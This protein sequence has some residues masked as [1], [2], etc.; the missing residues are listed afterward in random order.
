MKKKNLFQQNFVDVFQNISE[1][2]EGVSEKSN[3]QNLEN[4]FKML[5]LNFTDLRV[6]QY[7]VDRFKENKINQYNIDKEN[8]T[9]PIQFRL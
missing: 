6:K 8:L 1:G 3:N 7:H 9:T 4:M 5:Y 2:T